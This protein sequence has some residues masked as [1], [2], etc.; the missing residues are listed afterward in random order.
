M[1]IGEGIG[2]RTLLRADCGAEIVYVRTCPDEPA[3]QPTCAC[4]CEFWET[5][6]PE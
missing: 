5:S 1:A 6:D 3:T 2:E 4:G